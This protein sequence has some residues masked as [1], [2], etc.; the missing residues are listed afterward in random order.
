MSREVAAGGVGEVRSGR[1]SRSWPAREGTEGMTEQ[2]GATLRWPDGTLSE[3]QLQAIVGPGAPFEL[4]EEVVA[5]APLRV[6]ARRHHSLPEVLVAASD[7]FGERP[8]VVFSDREFTY[9]SIVK[10]VASVARQLQDRYGLGKGDRVALASA[11]CAEY[12]VTMWA[13]FSLGAIVVALNGWWTGSEM[14]YALEL[15]S[16]RL[17]LGDR[18]RLERLDGH[19]FGP[20]PLGVFEDGAIDLDPSGDLNLPEVTLHE[21]EPCLMLFT[22]GT[23]GRSKA[24]V[25]SHRNNIHFGQALLLGGAEGAVRA[26]GQGTPAAASPSP[27]CVI[28]SMPLFHTSGLSGQLIAG[29]F[30]GMT[31]VFPDV[32][33]W[34]EDVHLELTQKHKATMWSVVP[35]QLWRLLDWP[36]F[37][38]YDLS[39]LQRVGGGGSVWPPELLRKLEQRLPGMQRTVGYGMTE[40]TSCGTSLKGAASFDHPDSVGQPGPT[41]AIQVRDSATNEVLSEG[42]IGEICMRS[43]GTFLG[44]WQDPEATARVLEPD[45]WY[46][47]G[48]HGYFRDGFV[49]LGGRRTDLI[50]RGGENI[51]PIEIENRLVEHADVVEAAVVG[52]P[53]PTLGQ[54]VHAFV[55]RR[56]GSDLTEE[57]V[58]AWVAQ[59]LAAFK[60]PNGVAFVESMPHNAAG[61]LMKHLLQEP[62]QPSRFVPE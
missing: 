39:S 56:A 15:T 24:A 44:Y 14:A 55:V 27:G 1:A 3:R 13:A 16:P 8:Y 17:L 21:D 5:G 47:T 61:K 28:S 20:T 32:G 52:V 45:G 2:S 46:H 33:R 42:E 50:I 59:G 51:Y 7:R 48:D 54:E 58:R 19:Q 18:R 37:D 30:T 49:Y 23:T 31:T 4:V 41:V 26:L 35:T 40:T 9:G 34:R 6:F 29:M 53:H 43:A 62:G 36:D 11:S 10:T 12:V 38:R 22:S 25:L 57:D 60:V